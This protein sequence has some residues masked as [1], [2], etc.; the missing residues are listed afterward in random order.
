MKRKYGYK[1]D[2]RDHRDKLYRLIKP[3]ISLPVAVDL[4]PQC[5]LVFDQGQLGSCTA[6]GLAGIVEFMDL[7][8]GLSF[9]ELSRLFIYFN[10]RAMEGDIN[11]DGGAQIRDGVKSLASQGVCEETLWPYDPQWF[12]YKPS[13]ICYDDASKR[14]I[15]SYHRLTSLDDMLSCLAEGYPFVF[16]ISVFES[17]ESP[18][19]AQTGVVPMPGPDEQML[20]GHCMY[21]CGYDQD[22]KH[23]IVMNSWGPSWG[24]AGACF[25]PYEYVEKCADDFWTIRK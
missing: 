5:P 11:Q 12:A 10:E 18:E 1:P 2:L 23:F 15:Q 19:V 4:R 24:M 9:V 14:T 25:I 7:K 21:A 16:G 17:F 22:K 6:N 3:A 20:G 13:A 8:E